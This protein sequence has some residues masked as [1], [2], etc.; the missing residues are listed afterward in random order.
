VIASIPRPNP[1]LSLV[2]IVIFLL[3]SCG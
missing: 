3:L 2:G 1:R